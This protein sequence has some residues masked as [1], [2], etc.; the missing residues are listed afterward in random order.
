MQGTRTQ[1]ASSETT[2]IIPGTKGYRPQVTQDQVFN[3]D[4]AIGRQLEKQKSP[5]YMVAFLHDGAPAYKWVSLDKLQALVVKVDRDNV[6]AF[7]Y[8]GEQSSR[9]YSASNGNSP[10]WRRVLASGK[11]R[12]PRPGKVFMETDGEVY[13]VFIENQ[14]VLSIPVCSSAR[15][16]VSHLSDVDEDDVI[17]RCTKEQGVHLMEATNEVDPSS[18]LWLPIQLMKG[19]LAQRLCANTDY[20]WEHATDPYLS[21]DPF[22][23]KERAMPPVYVDVTGIPYHSMALKVADDPI[24]GQYFLR[25]LGNGRKT[26]VRKS[27]V[28]HSAKRSEI[29]GTTAIGLFDLMDSYGQCLAVV[30]GNENHCPYIGERLIYGEVVEDAETGAHDRQFFKSV[31]E[32]YSTLKEFEFSHAL[33]LFIANAIVR[34]GQDFCRKKT[35]IPD[36]LTN[37]EGPKLA[38]FAPGHWSSPPF[39]AEPGTPLV[40][41]GGSVKIFLE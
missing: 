40:S 38:F 34:P 35:L 9:M 30:E 33:Y 41:P 5:K 1:E 6:W 13:N 32:A 24:V 37:D 39:N 22:G 20:H 2:S 4:R 26:V 7:T 31:T 10:G 12:S 28:V 27:G 19:V 36:W 23:L 8:E 18:H 14:L 25:W 21:V 15:L 29:C 17:C 3:L 11:V 16:M